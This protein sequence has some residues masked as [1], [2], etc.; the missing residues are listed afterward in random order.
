MSHFPSTVSRMLVLIGSDYSLVS[1]GIARLSLLGLYYLLQLLVLLL[2][3]LSF[4]RLI[5]L[6]LVLY[7][8]D[9]IV[10]FSG[11]V[12]VVLVA[13]V[14]VLVSVPFVASVV[15]HVPRVVFHMQVVVV[16][17]VVV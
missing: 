2:L 11:L 7:R 5:V 9:L 8:I 17:V 6:L 4:S 1:L 12:L 10:L 16:S 13:A 3:W 14:D 15:G